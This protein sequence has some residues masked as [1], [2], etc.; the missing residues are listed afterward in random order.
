MKI[1]EIAGL[2]GCSIQTIRFYERKKLLPKPE[3][4]EG[5][6]RL[7]NQTTVD[8]LIFI[9]QCRAQ[10]MSIQEIN[11]LLESK[12]KPEQS[13]DSVNAIID[14]HL[15]QIT[16]KIS[17]LNAL[18]ESLTQMANSCTSNRKIK[19]CGILSNLTKNI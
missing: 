18:R 12:E 1:G 8:R 14:E 6:Y 13:C 4:S 15:Q 9:K 19:D 2:T 17:E 11:F 7:Y 3:R 16:V 10:D 5:N